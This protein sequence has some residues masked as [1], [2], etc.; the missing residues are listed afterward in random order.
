MIIIIIVINRLLLRVLEGLQSTDPSISQC[1]TLWI[2]ILSETKQLSKVLLPLYNL[3]TEVTPP[4]RLPQYESPRTP[5]SFHAHAQ[6]YFASAIL[7]EDE[8]VKEDTPPYPLFYFTQIVDAPRLQYGLSLFLSL[9]AINPVAICTHLA[10]AYMDHSSGYSSPIDPT[11]EYNSSPRIHFSDAGRASDMSRN[12]ATQRSGR[13]QRLQSSVAKSLLELVLTHCSHIL[14]TDYSTKLDIASTDMTA[15]TNIKIIAVNLLVDI[16]E[17]IMSIVSG[18]N[19]PE[20]TNGSNLTNSTYILCLLALCEIQKSTLLGLLQLIDIFKHSS[21]PNDTELKVNKEKSYS[22]SFSLHVSLP[23]LQ[24]LFVQ[25][26]KAL[27]YGIC[28][29]SMATNIAESP[30]S[31]RK[32]KRDQHLLE[33]KKIL[34]YVPGTSIVMQPL[35]FHIL[36]SILSRSHLVLQQ[37]YLLSVIVY[38]MLHFRDSLEIIAPKILK[39]IYRNLKEILSERDA[40]KNHAVSPDHAVTHDHSI[41]SDHTVKPEHVTRNESEC[42]RRTNSIDVVSWDYSNSHVK[43]CQTDEL[44]AV[45]IRTISHI[46]HYCLLRSSSKEL[47]TKT[48]KSVLH[49]Q[50]TD[51]LWSIQTFELPST[52]KN[53]ESSSGSPMTVPIVQEKAGFSFGWLFGGVFN[54]YSDTEP[55]KQATENKPE[56]CGVYAPVGQKVLWQLQHVYGVVVR[57]WKESLSNNEEINSALKNVSLIN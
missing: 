49:F 7:K 10:L 40:T 35:F 51:P 53:F 37:T 32:A 33:E 19:R 38:S 36:N 27:Y 16:L 26:L 28:L 52:S 18:K 50:L 14:L 31:M 44:I 11:T 29:E 56:Y 39:Q 21:S 6:Y 45:Y 15:L 13:P 41:Q 24:P 9:L 1:S 8:P 22:G 17:C 20:C 55:D 57:V 25:L 4:K 5:K 47:L 43:I 42:L 12:S 34:S 3:I 23:H 30:M 48:D 46:V 54:G 2:N